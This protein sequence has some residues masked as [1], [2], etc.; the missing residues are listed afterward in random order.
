VIE[1]R[2]QFAFE[3]D[4]AVERDG[5]DLFVA[6]ITDRWSIGGRPNGGYL[7][8]TILRALSH[9]LSHPIL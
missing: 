8:G 4:T 1:S 9:R 6:T 2:A 5:T 7:M 3:Q